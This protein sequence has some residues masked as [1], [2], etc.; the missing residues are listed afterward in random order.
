MG[1]GNDAFESYLARMGGFNHLAVR[2]GQLERGN[3]VCRAFVAGQ[4]PLS[5]LVAVGLSDKLQLGLLNEWT[6]YLQGLGQLEAA[7]RCQR[8]VV[9]KTK[10]HQALKDTVTA[11]NNLTYLL[12]LCG[13]L[14][15]MEA[16]ASRSVHLANR[17][18]YEA[19][20]LIWATQ[21]QARALRGKSKMARAYFQNVTLDNGLHP[22]LFRAEFLSRLGQSAE[23]WELAEEILEHEQA[24]ENAALYHLVHV[25]LLLAE[26]ARRRGDRLRASQLAAAAHSWALM[27]NAQPLL[28]ASAVVR[29][30]IALDHDPSICREIV[31]DG[32]RIALD[33]GFGIHH[34]DL[35]VVRAKLYLNEGRYTDATR[36][37]TVALSEG[38]H[39]SPESGLP[40]LL[41]AGDP[42]CGYSWGEAEARHIL[43]QALL[44]TAAETIGDRFD[45]AK[46]DVLPVDL[47]N[48]ISHARFELTNCLQIRRRIGDSKQ[49]ETERILHGL[50]RGQLVGR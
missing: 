8:A 41:A 30:R 35:L 9:R 40:T 15:E 23:A 26:L 14:R 12:E 49:Y 39:P 31:E 11:S 1:N 25:K 17:I 37:A 19:V 3:R 45:A 34:I 47:R 21:A 18:D 32:L 2:L 44:L 10:R 38:V 42:E 46:L 16:V 36:D 29:A 27:C 28:C 48:L 50:Q 24:S 20:D 43:A 7:V 22:N 5:T 33:C 6:V 4:S 13:R